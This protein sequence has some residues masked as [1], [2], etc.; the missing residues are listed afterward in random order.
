[1]RAE[2]FT[3]DRRQALRFVWSEN[4]HRRHLNSSQAGMA[5]AFRKKL[6][7][8]FMREFVDAV[9]A[10]AK[11]RQKAGRKKGGGDRKSGKAKN[12]SVQKVAPSDD[13]PDARK[14]RA[15]VAKA[16]GTNHA[17]AA[18]CEK[19]LDEEPELAETIAAGELS[20][21]Q[22]EREIKKKPTRQYGTRAP[23]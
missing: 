18:K 23:D 20:V 2:E 11:E 9:V 15:V 4:F 17:T 5:L 7:P 10:E 13:K 3:G 1:V 12:R 19:I 14:T 21:T 16:G 8:D 6:D 22:A